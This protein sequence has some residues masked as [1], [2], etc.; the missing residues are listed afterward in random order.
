MP[1]KVAFTPKAARDLD[2]I[3]ASIA[4][5]SSAAIASN[6]IASIYR[7]CQRIALAP[8]QGTKLHNQRPGIRTT[9]FARRV[10]IAFYLKSETV[11]ILSVAYGGRQHRKRL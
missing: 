3:E 5:E 7:R 2:R 11:V 8:D 9:G 6:Y 4:N 1:L 10:S